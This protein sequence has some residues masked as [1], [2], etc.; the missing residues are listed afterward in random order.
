MATYPNIPVPDYPI[1]ESIYYDVIQTNIP[2]TKT[3]R[4]RHTV[5]L[6][7]WVLNMIIKS[8]FLLFL[9]ILSNLI[10]IERYINYF[11]PNVSKINN[12]FL[13]CTLIKKPSI[14]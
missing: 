13:L 8:T 5:S 10:E 14:K 4:T 2:G 3:A 6:R 7:R 11:I 1:T 12:H 9:F